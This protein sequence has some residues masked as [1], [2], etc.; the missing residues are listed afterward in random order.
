[1]AALTTNSMG[2]MTP[3]DSGPCSM[4]RGSDTLGSNITALG[5]TSSTPPTTPWQVK[6]M[7]TSQFS[8]VQTLK[9]EGRCSIIQN[10]VTVPLQEKLVSVMH[11]CVTK[12]AVAITN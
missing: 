4:T 11:F 5:V 2:A 1:M 6:Q 3:Y 8:D 10:K 7:Q 12:L 9:L